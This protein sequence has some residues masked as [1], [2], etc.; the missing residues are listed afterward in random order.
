MTG[1]RPEYTDDKV[2]MR[3]RIRNERTVELMFE[4]NHYYIDSRRWKVAPERMKGPLHGIHIEK[5][6]VS[7]DN[8]NGRKYIRK[9]L[10]ANRQSAWKDAM[11]YFFLP[12][13]EA[14]K[15]ANYVN[16]ERW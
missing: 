12:S 6:D 15:L 14:N 7:K 1:V 13:E 5:T 9:E 3:D 8:P 16:N 11:Y 4:G 10:P 2:K